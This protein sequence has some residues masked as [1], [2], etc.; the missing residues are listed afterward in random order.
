MSPGDTWGRRLILQMDKDKITLLSETPQS[1]TSRS[2]FVPEQL[3]RLSR[4]RE[5]SLEKVW[6]FHLLFLLFY[7]I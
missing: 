7:K 2:I 5:V 3:R 1:Q 4:S 6:N